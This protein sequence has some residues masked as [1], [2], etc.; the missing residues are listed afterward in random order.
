MSGLN[1]SLSKARVVHVI[2]S[3]IVMW[4]GVNKSILE[5][6]FFH[7]AKKKKKKKNLVLCTTHHDFNRILGLING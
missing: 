4:H 5:I 3:I 7:L 1:N 6:L 2:L